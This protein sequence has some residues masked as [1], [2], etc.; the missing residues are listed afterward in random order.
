MTSQFTM[1]VC[2]SVRSLV[3][4]VCLPVRYNMSK[5]A[6]LMSLLGAFFPLHLS[7]FKKIFFFALISLDSRRK[8]KKAAPGAARAN[9]YIRR[10]DAAPD[11]L[12]DRQSNLY[13]LLRT[14]KDTPGLI[15]L[16]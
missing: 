2:L 9:R 4:Y 11:G 8:T 15:T 13:G 14:R 16:F 10:S 3:R 6:E 1:S 12:T 5:L 7:F